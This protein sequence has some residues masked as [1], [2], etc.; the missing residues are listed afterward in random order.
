MGGIT[1]AGKC[2][3]C[4]KQT[5]YKP[6]KRHVKQGDKWLD[7]LF[8]KWV[9]PARVT[10]NGKS[11]KLNGYG[12][13]TLRR[14][15]CRKCGRQLRALCGAE[16][17]PRAKR[18]GHPSPAETKRL[19]LLP[20]QTYLRT[21]HWRHVRRVILDERGH[22]CE[23]CGASA[24]ILH[25]HHLNYTH[26]GRELKHKDTLRVLCRDCHEDAHQLSAV[27]A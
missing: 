12:V 1:T 3:C 5:A 25:L 21:E 8:S 16:E 2:L 13:T 6:C 20:Y 17:L 15:T 23:E 22:V 18:I 27:C 19:R 9:T 11:V 14:Y 4:G 24:V 10:A 26:R 7:R